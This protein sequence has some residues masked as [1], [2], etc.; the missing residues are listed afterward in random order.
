MPEMFP[1]LP[2]LLSKLA[3]APDAHGL[4]S[5]FSSQNL[6]EARRALRAVAVN[7]EEQATE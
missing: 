6:D 1:N 3:T 7:W 2:E 4:A 5:A